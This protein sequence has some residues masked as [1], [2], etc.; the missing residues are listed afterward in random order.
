MFRSTLIFLISLG[1]TLPAFAEQSASAYISD[2]QQRASLEG[3][4]ENMLVQL[5]QSS[6]VTETEP[7]LNGGVSEN[8]L[9]SSEAQAQAVEALSDPK[10]V[11]HLEGSAYFD[12]FNQG[13]IDLSRP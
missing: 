6:L 11:E 8:G 9:F 2:V 4:A 3:Q 5:H 7:C 10:L 13:R 12:A 1:F